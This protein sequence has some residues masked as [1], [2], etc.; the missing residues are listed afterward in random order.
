MM[1]EKGP[2]VCVL[3]TDGTNNDGE[4]AHAFAMQGARTR[5][6]HVNELRSGEYNLAREAEILALPGG[7]ADGDDVAAGKILAVR[8]QTVLQDQVTDFIQQRQGLVYAEC[9][10]FQAL[11]KSGLLP[12]GEVGTVEATLT[13][14]DSGHFE[15]RWIPVTV[16]KGSAC[17]FLQGMEGTTLFQVAHGEGKFV[18]TSDALQMLEEQ[19]QVVFRYSD[20]DGNPTQDHRYNPNGSVH[21]IAGICDPTGRILGMMPHPSRSVEDTQILH[22]AALRGKEPP[23]LPIFQGAV[24]FASQM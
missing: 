23:G 19:R 14:N 24:V 8:F 11:V 21:A 22:I 3:I 1:H 9:N 12:S 17:V 20:R 5:I 7:F 10:G 13:Q 16:E 6:V 2:R 4:M 15:C 18:A